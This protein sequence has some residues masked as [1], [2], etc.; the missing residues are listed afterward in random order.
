L[1]SQSGVEHQER[2]LFKQPM[3]AAELRTLLG[4]R[5]AREIFATRSPKFK[6][7][8]LSDDALDDDA[9][10][11]LMEQYPQLIRRPLVVVDGQIVVGF[12]AAR[13]KDAVG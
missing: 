3:S 5:S 11:R 7:L 10:L 1:L 2:E 4:D 13:L 9:R 8:G 12:D 6:E